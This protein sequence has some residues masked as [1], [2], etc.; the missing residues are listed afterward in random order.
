M[1]TPKLQFD[2]VPPGVLEAFTRL[3]R[4]LTRAIDRAEKR[5]SVESLIRQ[6]QDGKLGIVD[7]HAKQCKQKLEATLHNANE[8]PPG[9]PMGSLSGGT[10]G[11]LAYS[12]ET[13]TA[14]NAFELTL[15]QGNSITGTSTPSEFSCTDTGNVEECKNGSVRPNTLVTGSFDHTGT[16]AANCG[17]V[18]VAFSA[19]NGNTWFATAPLTGPP[20]DSP[21]TV[22]ISEDDTWTWNTDMG[23][24]YV[25][26]NVRTTSP[27]AFARPTSLGRADT[28]RRRTASG[29]WTRTAAAS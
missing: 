20:S 9:S 21:P 7:Q 11:A 22:T 12:I 14:A 24:A 5:E 8:K 23:K 2:V 27:Q 3:D 18:Q 10:G 13:N 6:I 29:R 25:C 1:R 28:T 19:D 15:P 17:C 4:Q 26:V 16:I